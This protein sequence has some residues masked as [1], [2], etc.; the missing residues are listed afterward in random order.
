MEP[1][2]QKGVED[3]LFEEGKITPDQ[4]SAVKFEHIN[5]G[6]AVE[7][8]LAERGYVSPADL[9]AA[10]GKLLGTPYIKLGTRPI[11]A[12]VLDLVPEPT[13]RKYILIPFEKEGGV[14]SVAMA[15]PLD[16]QIIEFLEKR[17]NLKV[18]PFIAEKEDIE[19]SIEEE[20]RKALGQ[21]VTAALEEVGEAATKIEES[22][23]DISRAEEVIRDAPV[24]RIV[25]TILE[26]AVKSRASDVHLEPEEK[27]TRI[28]YRIDGVLQERLSLPKKVHDSVI[29]RVKILS[30]L[31][32]D[33]RRIPQ[34]GRFKIEVGDRQIDLRVST[35]P[36][37]FGEKCVIRLLEGE[38]K[39]M[40]FAE[41]GLRGIS[42]KRFDEALLRPHGIVLVTGPT[43][44]GKTMT[45]AS[46]LS[47]LN[48]IRINIMTLE[49]PVEIRVSGVNQV[50]IN[51]LAGLTFANGLRSFVRQ[52]P[53]VI[54]VGEIRDTETAELAIHAALTGHLVL[55]TLHTNSAAGALPRLTDMGIETFLLASTV[56]I[57][58]AQRL[59]RTVCE[60]CREKY[61]APP[62]LVE[63]I[64]EVLGPLFP[65]QKMSVE[66]ISL[67]R[68]KGCKVCGNTGFLGRT[69]IFEVLNISD[70]ITRLILEHQPTAEIHKVAVEEGMVTLKQDGYLKAL[71]GVTT[72]E[73][74]LRVARD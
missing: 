17:T 20:Y 6:K 73:E 71:E 25:G 40:T 2:S 19:S 23:E 28:R 31:K 51:P 59:V 47:K 63:D 44:S 41:L 60:G 61:E 5:T 14:L 39:V 52:D 50:Q 33:E 4:L 56:N 29:S 65:S 48:S 42:L 49:D 12:E 26:Y 55:S 22:I 35:M 68:G 38:G 32:I 62:Q 3:I 15:D 8:I 72:I 24:A 36:T 27:H 1:Q 54:M 53:D 69:G 70:R 13:A 10:R 37:I 66:K 30:N 64:K 57:A 74:V 34:D 67:P 21:E 46:A 7:N 18:K 43:G 45:L 58:A 16:L 11:K 9:T